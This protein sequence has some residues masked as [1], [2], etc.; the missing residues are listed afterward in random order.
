MDGFNSV[1]EMGGGRAEP[2]VG[3]QYMAAA[4]CCTER[5]KMGEKGDSDMDAW[6]NGLRLSLLLH[7]RRPKA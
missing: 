6:Y 1:W 7:K 2:T 5:M 3:M 4:L